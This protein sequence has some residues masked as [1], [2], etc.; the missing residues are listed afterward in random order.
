MSKVTKAIGRA[1]KKTIKGVVK[2]VKKIASSKIGKILIA[3]ATIYFGGAA[4]LG[5]MGGASA[6]TGLMGTISGA[7][8]GAG[9]GI[10]SAW[11]GLTGATSAAM[12]GNFS[13][14]GSSLGSGFTGA[15]AA[16]AQAVSGAAQG[17]ATGVTNG[18]TS[19]MQVGL[20]GQPL[21]SAMQNAT[22]PTLQSLGGAPLDAGAKA[23]TDF[24]GDGIISSAWNGLG[25]FG[26]MAAIQ[27]SMQIAG[28]ALQGKAA[29]DQ[30]RFDLK[31]Q[32]AAR[33]R[34]NTN[35]GTRLWKDTAYGEEEE[36]TPEDQRYMYPTRQALPPLAVVQ[37]PGLVRGNMIVDPRL[38]DMQ[39]QNQPVYRSGIA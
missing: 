25:D 12:G 5:A 28:G 26:K 23:A 15:N 11:S 4:I 14:A 2:V 39:M 10:S 20:D 35:V 9:A 6:S 3:A 38:E 36:M 33:D 29:E 17:V 1:I 27:G 37:R 34:Y 32:A 22:Q 30:R 24:G 31:Q 18:M 8:K 13:A 21:A 16:G 19:G 7:L